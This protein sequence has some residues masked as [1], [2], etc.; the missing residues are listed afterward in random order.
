MEISKYKTEQLNKRQRDIFEIIKVKVIQKIQKLRNK[1]CDVNRR[2]VGW[3][4]SSQ[5]ENTFLLD[6]IWLWINI[7]MVRCD[8]PRLAGCAVR[9]RRTD[10][11]CL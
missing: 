6:Y 9:S 11:K 1:I 10:M 2:G 8:L 3:V 4:D 5:Y 7:L